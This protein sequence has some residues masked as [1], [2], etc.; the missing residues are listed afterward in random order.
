METKKNPAADLEPRRLLMFQLGLIISLG[1]VLTAFEWKT[2]DYSGI[3]LPPPRSIEVPE[4]INIQ[5]VKQK[6]EL[7]KPVNTT[8]MHIT[9][10][11]IDPPID[12]I[13]DAGI[14]PGEWVPTFIP[15]VV[16]EE[17]PVE[18][19]EP[20]II[21]EKMPVFGSGHADLLIYLS[22][23]MK[24]PT[25]ARESGI[26]GTV[27]ISFVVE[28]DGSLSDIRILRELGGGCTAEAI[29][30]IQNMPRWTPGNQRGIPVRVRMNLPVKFMLLN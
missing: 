20:F 3:T 1:V 23:N 30:V 2:P 4:D 15:P 10:D 27:Y 21:V 7:P 22:Q 6:V 18:S 14:D 17:V 28:K 13:I 8:L 26:S 11:A 12:L 9:D 29:R 5:T 25:M 16:T 24:Y 19:D